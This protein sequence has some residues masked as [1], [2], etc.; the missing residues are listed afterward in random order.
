VH[1]VEF[2]GR[3]VIYR[4]AKGI[5]DVVE[6]RSAL[7]NVGWIIRGP[8]ATHLFGVRVL[9]MATAVR[10]I[11]PMQYVV[12]GLIVIFHRLLSHAERRAEGPGER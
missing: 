4:D 1:V 11:D 12:H 7:D 6:G 8:H 2:E 3:V 5:L 9:W 10:L